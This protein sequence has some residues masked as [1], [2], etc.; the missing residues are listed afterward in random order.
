M[1]KAKS[2]ILA[3][4]EIFR[5]VHPGPFWASLGV[6][7]ISM[8]GMVAAFGTS[9]S[10]VEISIAQQTVVEQLAPAM[11]PA[12]RQDNEF[13]V[14]EDHVQ[15]GDSVA[16]LLA[17]LDIQD[18]EAFR[19][20]RTNTTTQAIFRQL[21]PGKQ[22]TAHV[23]SGGGLQ[24]L[25]YPL[26]TNDRALF[27]ERRDGQLHASERALPLETEVQ[28]KSGEIRYSLFGATDEAGIPD[29]IAMQLVDI[30]GGDIDFH[31]GLQLGD[32]F[33]VVY[34]TLNHH[35]KLIRSGRVLAAE[36]VNAGKTYRAVWFE[37]NDHAHG[38]YYTPEGKSLRKAF[39]RS[40]LEFSRISSGFT[41]ARLHP[42]K[43]T[44]RAHKGIDYAAPT[45]TKVKS[46][47]D[48]TV[49][50]VGTQNGFGRVVI[51]R[52]QGRYTTVYAH[53]SKF[54]P[55]LR[56]GQR[57]SQGEVIGNVGSTGWATGPHLH[58]EFRVNNVQ[59]N[60]L[61]VA[62]PTAVPL[63]RQQLA[64]FRSKAEPYLTQ[65]NLAAPRSL[66]LLD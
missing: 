47:A 11:R 40:P 49:D 61:S 62:L 3:Q 18:D 44:W 63:T 13:F 38:S 64:S 20:L 5:V 37:S 21:R 57:V 34:E 46:T 48:G 7:G 36:F 4:L 17:R 31:R 32:R 19:F 29:G 12:M 26:N 8:F 43:Q 28:M 1:N 52:H 25:I 16:S 23:D 2:R 60:P 55:G 58:Y 14:R 24:A 10:T 30:F 50:F 53:L 15:R 51:L 54:A 35:G 56:K 42:I 45:G 22:V 66:A 27:I 59:Q 9:P 39:L 41:S 33:S 65:L 6:A